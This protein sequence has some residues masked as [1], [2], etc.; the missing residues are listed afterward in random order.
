MEDGTRVPAESLLYGH[1]PAVKMRRI[2]EPG[3][4]TTI[5]VVATDAVLT[6]EQANR[7][8]IVAHDGLARAIRPVHTQMDGDTVFALATGR[9]EADVNFIQLCALASEVTARAILNGVLAGNTL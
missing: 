4:N 2:Q 9:V 1:V 5:A 7:L 3:Q 6:K 8:A